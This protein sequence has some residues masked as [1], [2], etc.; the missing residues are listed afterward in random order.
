MIIFGLKTEVVRPTETLIPMYQTR[1]YHDP[2]D[3]NKMNQLLQPFSNFVTPLVSKI[4]KFMRILT[5]DG[6]RKNAVMSIL[7]SPC[8]VVTVTAGIAI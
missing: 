6:Q 8:K 7:A 2:H 4:H 1:Q 3:H 5:L